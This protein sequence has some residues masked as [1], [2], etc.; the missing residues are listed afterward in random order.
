M[1]RSKILGRARNMAR[2]A[3]FLG[4]GSLTATLAL[5]QVAY[6]GE[7]ADDQVSTLS[8]S[9]GA[10]TPIAKA[11]IYGTTLAVSPSGAKAY[12][13]SYNYFNRPTP[14][15][16]IVDL[17]TGATVGTITA[18]PSPSAPVLSP[19]GS[20]L[21]V[22]TAASG[23]AAIDTA[24][25]TL[26]A[27]APASGV[28]PGIA[29]KPDGS[30]VYAATGGVVSVFDAHSL[31]LK[32]V[33]AVVDPVALVFSSDGSRL[34]AVGNS[35]PMLSV[36]DT[37]SYSVV[38]AVLKPKGLQG[39]IVSEAISPD[40]QTVYIGSTFELLSVSTASN[41]VTGEIKTP[42]ALGGS[43]AV[44]MG[45]TSVYATRSPS[46]DLYP[47]SSPG[48]FQIDVASGAGST[49]SPSSEISALQ[50]PSSS[51]PIYLLEAPSMTLVEDLSSGTLT[52]RVAP[53]LG[54]ASLS[55]SSSGNTVAG[56]T[57]FANLSSNP[58]Q[59][60]V[61]ILNTATHRSSGEF[62]LA[63]TAPPSYPL[64]SG[65]AVNS[66][67]SLGYVAAPGIDA[68]TGEI[69]PE[70]SVLQLP[71]GT[72]ESSFVALPSTSPDISRLAI[73]PDD[74]TLYFVINSRLCA[75]A[76][77][78]PGNATCVLL[79]AGSTTGTAGAYVLSPDGASIY[80]VAS[81]PTANGLGYYLF[82][83]EVNAKTLASVKSVNI[84][85]AD[86]GYQPY[87]C[88]IAY[89]ASSNSAY[90]ACQISTF[91]QSLGAVIRVDFGSSTV[92]AAELL[93]FL[94]E[95]IAVAPDG[96]KVLV[97]G[98]I[99]GTRV[100]DGSTL[101]GIGLIPGGPGGGIVIAPQ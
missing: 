28:T 48:L 51:Q 11:G 15:V 34:Y 36:I 67:G 72:L 38:A 23:L 88:F 98:S 56:L 53:T 86:L 82:I 93:E 52:T 99:Q 25:G 4:T 41:A 9:T 42:G 76:V 95:G 71:Q 97:T 14:A 87:D 94:P 85:S 26:L 22:I 78:D 8:E 68:V 18:V 7:S 50:R 91:S 74:S 21:Y 16:T 92:A 57:L 43:L 27:T 5:C 32:S 6:V 73:S 29:V 100:F 84:P 46:P 20:L 45:G 54:T 19:D 37:A 47:L 58:T 55:V 64:P 60:I 3:Q 66:N 59:A 17:S 44:S 39:A 70:I 80:A 61:S 35:S 2:F 33:I 1:T 75:E 90:M 79:T 101:A 63:P 77:A 49:L 69:A 10:K 13:G 40:G 12:V 24:S 96:T 89:S 62:A 65:V 31:A 30:E 83:D 81:K